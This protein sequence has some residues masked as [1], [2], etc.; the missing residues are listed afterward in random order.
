M[1]DLAN[2]DDRFQPEP[3]PGA[4]H[5]TPREGSGDRPDSADRLLA[6]ALGGAVSEG[7]R[8][9]S[10]A[11][12]AR[13]TGSSRRTLAI[14]SIRGFDGAG[15]RAAVVVGSGLI[16]A[17]GIAAW[18]GGRSQPPSNAE[19]VAPSAPGGSTAAGSTL[20]DGAAAAPTVATPELTSLIPEAWR[21]R[22][23]VAPGLAG[24]GER[25][26]VCEPVDG[27]ARVELIAVTD[28]NARFAAT[29]AGPIGGRG[30]ARCASGV[31]EIRTWSHAD[32]PSRV[33]GRYSCRIV[34][35]RAE[36]VWSDT[37]LGIVGR[38]ISEQAD[39]A[40]LYEWW[41]TRAPGAGPM[42]A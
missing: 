17:V 20:A 7:R 29:V 24:A 32:D 41:T 6:E 40:T 2:A 1:S 28:P 10:E 35:R 4:D 19:R 16:V 9:W 5:P 11:R 39:L 22:C 36:L 30:A 38:A 8:F 12:P 15:R 25:T 31:G 3:L 33:V 37:E 42:A 21:S 34:G 13:E 27:P 14:R 18:A 26:I 23:R